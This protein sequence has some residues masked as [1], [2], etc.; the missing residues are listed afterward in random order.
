MSGSSSS[1]STSDAD[2]NNEGYSSEH[3]FVVVIDGARY[4]ETFGDAT[5]QYI[6]HIWNDLRP[7]GCIITSFYNNGITKTNSAHASMLTGTWQTI[8][9]DGS[10]R[11]RRPTLFEYRRKADL[12][13]NQ[14]DNYVVAGKSKLDILNY[15]TYP[16]YGMAYSASVELPSITYN[17]TAVWNALIDVMDREHPS[18]VV[19][20]L[21]ETDGDGH[22]GV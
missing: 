15:S 4:T 14:T 19:V 7:E 21:A 11:A 3:I 13:V 16:E 20:N 6:P 22:S 5:H 8:A 12:S 2:L 1:D 9:N 18:L 17:D 10:E